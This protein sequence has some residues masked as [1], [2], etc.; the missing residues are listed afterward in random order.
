MTPEQLAELEQL[1]GLRRRNVQ[2]Q[3]RLA[4]L[5]ILKEG[6]YWRE[7]GIPQP[8][9]Q[10]FQKKG[11]NA[12]D[13]LI[14]DYEQNAL[15]IGSDF[16]LI[17]APDREI[18]RFEVLLNASRTAIEEEGEWKLATGDFPVSAHEKGTGKTKGFLLLQALITISGN[19]FPD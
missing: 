7:N 12:N 18:Y 2:E 11:L 1:K 4:F 14:H 10:F 9:H 19:E 8:L 15:G 6:Y 5:R 3:N 13:C 17:V 16:G